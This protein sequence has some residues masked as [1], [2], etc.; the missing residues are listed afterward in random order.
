MFFV[1]LLF[2]LVVA[3]LLTAI[4][5]AGFRNRGPW[6]LW[7][8][9]LLVVF[10]AAWAGGVWLTPFGPPLLDVYW[11]PFLFVGLVV[12]LLIAAA[13]PPE[14]RR[15]RA[16]VAASEVATE[17][18]VAAFSIFFWVLLIGLALAIILWYV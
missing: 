12:A 13:V 5:S 2:A 1:D 9:F 11:L 14:P 4:F 8:V 15:P 18:A 6:G 10:L 7:W 3:L 17:E 16:P